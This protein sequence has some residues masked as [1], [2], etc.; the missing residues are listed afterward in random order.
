VDPDAII[1]AD[2][3]RVR[4]VLLSLLDNAVKFTEQGEVTMTLRSVDSVAEVVVR[5]TG[6]GLGQIDLARLF[7]PF[8]QAD[9]STTRRFGGSGLGLYVAQRLT[10]MM[11]GTLH[12]ANAPQSQGAVATVT[13]PLRRTASVTR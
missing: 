9:G 3:E 12:L 8:A 7:E 13:F 11:G 6:V 10:Q 5:D 2:R 1:W 4:Q